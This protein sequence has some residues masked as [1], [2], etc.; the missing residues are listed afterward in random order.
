MTPA[1]IATVVFAISRQ[2]AERQADASVD[3][4]VQVGPHGDVVDRASRFE[5]LSDL[6]EGDEPYMHF[7]A[8]QLAVE[9]AYRKGYQAG[10]DAGKK[11]ADE[12]ADAG[13]RACV[14]LQAGRLRIDAEYQISLASDWRTAGRSSDAAWA[15]AEAALLDVEA[16]QLR[17]WAEGATK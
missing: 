8:V 9:A 13:W 15:E 11:A 16:A 7:N 2:R 4:Y 5:K 17:A 3:T 12:T 1:E 6:R 14:L 10:L